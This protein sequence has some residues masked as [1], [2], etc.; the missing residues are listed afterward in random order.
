MHVLCSPDQ[1]SVKWALLTLQ[2]GEV[3]TDTW[4]KLWSLPPASSLAL[5]PIAVRPASPTAHA[6]PRQRTRGGLAHSLM[7]TSPSRPDR[8]G[9]RLLAQGWHGC[10]LWTMSFGGH[11]RTQIGRQEPHCSRRSPNTSTLAST[12]RPSEPQELHFIEGNQD[13]SMGGGGE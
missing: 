12:T 1:E 3:V 9:I 13:L 6:T 11:H 2:I 5:V 4:Q 7:G 10:A 8:D